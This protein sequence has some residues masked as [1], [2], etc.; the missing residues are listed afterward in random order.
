MSAYRETKKVQAVLGGFSSSNYRTERLWA[1]APDGVRVPISLVYRKGAAKLD[2]TD[3][4][5]AGRVRPQALMLSVL[6]LKIAQRSCQGWRV[7]RVSWG[8]M[9]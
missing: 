1:T 5:L 2:G 7:S 9:A 8:Q 3:P 4:S 6:F